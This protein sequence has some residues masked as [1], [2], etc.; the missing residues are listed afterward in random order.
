[1]LSGQELGQ[2]MQRR[3]PSIA[4]G[5]AVAARLLQLREEAGDQIGA[6]IA[7]FE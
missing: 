7:D 1:M 2:R 6:Q 3:Q 4:R 5:D